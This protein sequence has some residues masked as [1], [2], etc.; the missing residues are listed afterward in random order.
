MDE[1]LTL[2]FKVPDQDFDG[3]SL[4]LALGWVRLHLAAHPY[5][6]DD[7]AGKAAYSILRTIQ[8][9]YNR[10]IGHPEWIVPT[11]DEVTGRA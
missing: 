9:E 2:T 11:V 5:P 7:T 4:E 1:Q 3:I 10:A 6:Q 8:A